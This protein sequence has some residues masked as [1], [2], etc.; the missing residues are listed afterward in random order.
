LKITKTTI[1]QVIQGW[2]NGRT[3]NQLAEKL[4]ISAGSV[5]KIL[6]GWNENIGHPEA[7]ELRGFSVMVKKS[8]MTIPQFVN[9]FRIHQLL[10]NFLNEDGTNRNVEED[11][12]NFHSFAVDL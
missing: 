8:G 10:K 2:L 11:L 9:A 6:E 1:D 5:S 4:C 12:D 3:R 7:E